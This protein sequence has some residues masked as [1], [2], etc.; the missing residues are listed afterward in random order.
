MFLPD[1]IFSE[2]YPQDLLLKI[3]RLCGKALLCCESI[4]PRLNTY[5]KGI[6]SE[7]A[8]SKKSMNRPKKIEVEDDGNVSLAEI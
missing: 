7:G 4:R 8:Q 1:I 6:S 5:T 3:Q 2:S